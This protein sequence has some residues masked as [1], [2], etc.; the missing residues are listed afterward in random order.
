[1]PRT[2]ERGWI[3]SIYRNRTPSP[4]VVLLPEWTWECWLDPV[5]LEHEVIPHATD[6]TTPSHAAALEALIEHQRENHQ[7]GS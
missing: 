5:E 1:M 7:E 6:T 2:L 3:A 4:N